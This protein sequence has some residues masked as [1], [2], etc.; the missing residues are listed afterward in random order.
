MLVARPVRSTGGDGGG[1]GGGGGA[2]T[3]IAAAGGGW[4]DVVRQ[5]V[6]VI[7]TTTA[8]TIDFKF[9]SSL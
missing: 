1:G 9:A 7:R 8:R 3:N 5:P 4:T 6:T 2:G